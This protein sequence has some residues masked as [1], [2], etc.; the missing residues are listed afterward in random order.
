[1]P[2][3]EASAEPHGTYVATEEREE[4]QI[5]ILDQVLKEFMKK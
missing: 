1:M 4:D 5:R 3:K 2:T